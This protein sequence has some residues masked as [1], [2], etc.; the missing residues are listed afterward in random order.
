MV[1]TEAYS[2]IWN[3]LIVMATL[4]MVKT[5]DT[6]CILTSSSHCV[7]Q[8]VLIVSTGPGYN[9]KEEVLL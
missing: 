9:S 4:K 7:Q 6:S 8:G 2:S 5:A 1:T 3:Y